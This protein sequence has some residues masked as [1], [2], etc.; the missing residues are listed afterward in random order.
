MQYTLN[1]SLCMLYHILFQTIQEFRERL[2]LRPMSKHEQE[3][4]FQRAQDSLKHHIQLSRIRAKA[5]IRRETLLAKMEIDCQ[6]IREAPSLD[7][8]LSDDVINRYL[9]PIAPVALSG[10]QAHLDTLQQEKLPW[11][12]K[13]GINTD[14]D[15]DDTFSTRSEIERQIDRIVKY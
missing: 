5:D 3:A 15:I 4:H 14:F 13:L 2:S 9:S 10:K 8:E 6:L 1:L 12:K 7:D 11:Y